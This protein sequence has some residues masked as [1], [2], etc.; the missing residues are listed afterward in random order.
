VNDEE[1]HC[2]DSAGPVANHGCPLPPPPM[3]VVAAPTAPPMLTIRREDSVAITYI[4]RNVLFGSNSDRFRDSS[5]AALDTLAGRLLAHP[6]W[7]L[8]IEGHTDNSGEPGKNMQ[9]SQHRAGAILTYLLKKGVPA[10]RL[11]AVGYGESRPVADNRT[12]AGRAANRRVELR[13]SI[14]K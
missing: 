6:E 11:T 1:D 2:P 8:T 10:K 13:L 12:P 5:F 3:P 7:H 4:A 9:L 14:E